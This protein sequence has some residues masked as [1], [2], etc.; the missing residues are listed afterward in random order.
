MRSA[1]VPKVF[2]L[3][4]DLNIIRGMREAAER[5]GWQ[6]AAASQANGAVEAMKEFAPDI[7]LLDVQLPDGNGFEVCARIAGDGSLT[8]VPV[9]FLTAKGDVESRLKGFSA[10]GRDYVAKPFSV[11][12]L[13]ARMRAHAS[14][15]QDQDNLKR[16]L[17]ELNLAERVREDLVDM[18]VH[19][20]RTPLGTI[21][22]TLEMV[23]DSGL[24]T[25]A[26]YA[27]ILENA[28]QA[29][30]F[31]LS[32]VND[33]LDVRLGKLRVNAE[34]LHLEALLDRIK[35]LFS[36]QL[37]RYG[38]ALQVDKIEAGEQS[39]TDETLLFR[40]LMNLLS[41]AVK[42]SR[43]GGRIELK[44][45]AANHQLRIET[46]DQG[47]GIPDAEKEKIFSKYYRAEGQKS[48]PVPGMGLGLA[49]CKLACE[50]LKGR[51]WVEDNT[52][53]GSRFILELPSLVAKC[54]ITI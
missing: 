6:F 50:T 21:E 12:E 8:K 18:I 7:I 36:G 1:G 19:D 14:I 46:A 30:E 29:A 9:I 53:G 24:I 52:G 40:I 5:E 25:D 43:S 33:I 3:E 16:R 38:I 4:D 17:Q 48:G 13:L 35:R 51:I 31:A 47:P 27:R 49:F 20:L 28:K 34:T 54:P 26:D 42:F 15:K 23:H 22:V 41:N 45:R 37:K 44:I 2:L 10:G 39:V 11:E 32:M